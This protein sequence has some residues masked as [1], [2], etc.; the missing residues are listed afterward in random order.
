MITLP[1]SWQ[2][3]T[4]RDNWFNNRG[5]PLYFIRIVSP[6]GTLRLGNERLSF[7]EID[8]GWAEYDNRHF[9]SIGSIQ[10]ALNFLQGQAGAVG[11]M[12]ETRIVISNAYVDG[13]RFK[14]LY[15]IDD[16]MYGQVDIWYCPKECGAP[17]EEGVNVIRKYKGVLTNAREDPDKIILKINE[18]SNTKHKKVPSRIDEFSEENS[19]GWEV[20]DVSVNKIVPICF[21]SGIFK[22]Y[23]CNTIDNGTRYYYLCYH[24]P[25]IRS[26]RNL[27]LFYFEPTTKRFKQVEETKFS[28]LGYLGNTLY[29]VRFDVS[30]LPIYE[31]LRKFI[32]PDSVVVYNNFQSIPYAIN[33]NKVKDG[34]KATTAD[35]S[36]NVAYLFTP[37]DS[38]HT[39][40]RL[41]FKK[42]QFDLRSN[43]DMYFV[44]DF[45]VSS[46]EGLKRWEAKATWIVETATF[47]SALWDWDVATSHYI[48]CFIPEDWINEGYDPNQNLSVGLIKKNVAPDD[49]SATVNI[50]VAEKSLTNPATNRPCYLYEAGLC[51]VAL[52]LPRDFYVQDD[53][54]NNTTQ[55]AIAFVFQNFLNISASDIIFENF[56]TDYK[57]DGQVYEEKDSYDLFM[58][59]ANQFGYIFFEDHDSKERFIEIAPAD[60]VYEITDD[61]I[62]DDEGVLE[63]QK[64]RTDEDVYSA[65]FVDYDKN[66]ATFEH[67]KSAY[68]TKDN[69]N[70]IHVDGATLKE[71]CQDAYDYY[72]TEKRLTFKLD[73]VR[74]RE[75][76]ERILAK[77][78]QFYS[79]K[80]IIIKLNTTLRLT[81]LEIGDQVKINSSFFSSANN[82]YVAGKSEDSDANRIE[83]IL[84]EAP[85]TSAG[86]IRSLTEMVQMNEDVTAIIKLADEETEQLNE[87]T[88][89]VI[90]DE[91]D[92]N[93][94]E[95]ITEDNYGVLV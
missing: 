18:Q 8:E 78:V 23:H 3:G 94:V 1:V 61:D 70:C 86:L 73:Y 66:Y 95:D 29:L 32:T 42:E 55:E 30:L 58:E 57:I 4:N 9:I 37:Q 39:P 31:E 10:F 91:G 79:R 80:R 63:I 62:V 87:A 90:G 88:T 85:W 11:Q 40:Y 22:A 81:D 35:A 93:V 27:D 2:V 49:L 72:A 43:F 6:T 52:A 38:W 56:T 36:E 84:F 25:E 77:L 82:F 64:Y 51:Q 74:D 44:A 46:T 21:G 60:S 12:G 5:T 59:F 71:F 75:T 15:N 41:T 83:F 89:V 48:C 19:L 16:Y 7:H 76:A 17:Y 92:E 28:E 33:G 53:F 65:F 24:Y 47:G 13:V 45:S 68:V 20:P 14:D 26:S 34:K 69:T 54:L 50:Y 67:E